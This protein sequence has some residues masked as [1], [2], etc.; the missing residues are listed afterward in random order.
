MAGIGLRQLI[1]GINEFSVEMDQLE[2]HHSFETYRKLAWLSRDLSL[3][4]ESGPR[5]ASVD[6]FDTSA[7]L[8]NDLFRR[9][10]KH[11]ERSIIGVTKHIDFILD[12]ISER[13]CDGKTFENLKAE[14]DLLVGYCL[15]TSYREQA[16]A[17]D[18]EL[19]EIEYSNDPQNVSYLEA[20]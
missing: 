15:P 3:Q 1:E 10:E 4:T 8:Y 11:K 2:G 19:A 17:Y 13:I 6:D 16:E 20:A 14:F 18:A 9:L 7:A 5:K 12:K